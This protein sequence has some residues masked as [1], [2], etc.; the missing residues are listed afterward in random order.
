[1]VE[2]FLTYDGGLRCSATHGPSG[3]EITT[4]APT[5]NLG[6]GESFSPTDL[7]ATSLG[8]CMVTTMAIFAQRQGFDFPAGAKLAVRKIMTSE[9]PRK[10][11]RIE[12]DLDIPLPADYPQRAELER[13]AIHC[14]VALTLHPDVKKA[15][16]FRWAG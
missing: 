10:I 6:K 14:P 7:C 2:F 8:V 3:R 4:D 16:A 13:V 1:M 9:P 5:D 11:A 12:V 15:L